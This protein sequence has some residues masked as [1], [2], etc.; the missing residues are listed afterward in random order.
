MCPE[1]FVFLYILLP[2]GLPA[3]VA[4]MMLW[5]STLHAPVHSVGYQS[6]VGSNE[7][8]W[9]WDLGRNK[10]YHDSIKNQPGRPYPV[11][12]RNEVSLAV[13]DKFLVVLDMDKGALGFVVNDIYLGQAF[14]ELR[15]KKLYLMVS[16]VW[17]HCEI[18]MK[19]LGGLDRKYTI[20]NTLKSY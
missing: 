9:G 4:P 19:Y 3:N 17:G 20:C 7:H 18:T 16:A 12:L 1:A 15:G 6:L 14:R 11:G 2:L 10:V 8:S 13:P 5:V